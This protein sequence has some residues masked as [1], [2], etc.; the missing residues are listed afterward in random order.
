LFFVIKRKDEELNRIRQ[1]VSDKKH[2][3][4]SEAIEIY[5][6]LLKNYKGL[7]TVDNIE[8]THRYIDI[9]KNILLF[10]SDPIIFKFFDFEKCGSD[11]GLKIYKY[12]ELIVLM[13]KD[14]GNDKTK[15][16]AKAMLRTLLTDEEEYQK[17][18]RQIPQALFSKSQLQQ[19][20]KELQSGMIQ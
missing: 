8:L 3:T 9:K 20:Q 11:S 16:N 10:A 15:L 1:K 5:F 18:I 19:D 13:R 2:D 4:Y 6:E 17:F 12:C 7:R 14:M